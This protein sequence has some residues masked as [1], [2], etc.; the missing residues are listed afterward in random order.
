MR[1]GGIGMWLVTKRA[2]TDIGGKED[3]SAAVGW[4]GGA[5]LAV[6]N[7]LRRPGEALPGSPP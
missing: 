1:S 3:A 2:P 6:R 7:P 5:A 4:Q